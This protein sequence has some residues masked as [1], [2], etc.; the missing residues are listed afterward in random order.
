[1]RYEEGRCSC[2]KSEMG[3]SQLFIMKEEIMGDGWC[4][5]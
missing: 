3:G 5:W 4:K 2:L 1:M